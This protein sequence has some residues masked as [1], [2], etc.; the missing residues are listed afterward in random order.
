PRRGIPEEVSSKLGQANVMYAMRDYP[1][2][3]A[4]LLEVVQTHPNVSDPYHTLGLLHE[5]IGQPRKA[6]DFF[7]I[8]AHLSPRDLPLWKRLASMSTELGFYRQAVYCLSKVIARDRGDLD[9]LWDRAVLY[10]QV[11]DI[12]KALAHFAEVGRARPGDPEVPVMQAR[13]HHQ[14][15][16][17]LKA[18]SVLEAHLRDHPARVDLTHI[19]ILAELYMERGGYAEARA[20]IERAGPVLCPDQALPLDLAVKAGLCLAHTGRWEEAEEVLGE[21]LREPVE[22]FGDLYGSVGAALAGLGQHDKALQYLTPLLGHPDYSEPGLWSQLLGSH[23]AGGR[24]GEGVALYRGQLEAMDPADARY[25]GAVLRLAEHC[26]E[27]GGPTGHSTA[28]EMVEL[29]DVYLQAQ[30]AAAGGGGEGASE[31]GRPTG[32]SLAAVVLGEE[33]AMR[34]SQLYL[35]LGLL[36]RY[37]QC[38]RPSVE[39]SLTALAADLARVS[40]PAL[41]RS[42]KRAIQRRRMFARRGGRKGEGAAEVGS[43]FKGAT[44]RDR[45][46]ARTRELDR[47]AAE[48]LGLPYDSPT[49]G[50]G[51]V[52]GGGTTD[53]GSDGGD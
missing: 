23:V 33:L 16:A 19:N 50:G 2:A 24:A 29:L 1:P 31:G 51:G 47:Q 35:G 48:V 27:L 36:D 53:A 41:P 5:A 22:Q 39:S 49:G 46:T 21:L 28:L 32:P 20:L 8:A 38:I 9:A 44:K 42:L 17:P 30:H 12:D 14:L 6:L 10:A 45:R 15:G 34:L 26:M 43:V 18:I 3:I 13:L 25:P 37:V 52:G 40:D 7:M 11:G 4:L